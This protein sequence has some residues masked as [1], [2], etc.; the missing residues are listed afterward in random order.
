M[1]PRSEGSRNK[2]A[3]RAEG[4]GIGAS[5]G[6]RA[7]FTSLKDPGGGLL[8]ERFEKVKHLKPAAS[9]VES[10]ET[11]LLASGYLRSEKAEQARD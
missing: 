11:Y 3:G 5:D 10:V 8:N 2:V 1:N 7:G 4:S 9:R 6:A